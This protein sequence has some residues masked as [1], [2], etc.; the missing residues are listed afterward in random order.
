LSNFVGMNEGH[1]SLFNRC[2]AEQKELTS[3]E[4]EHDHASKDATAAKYQLEELRQLLEDVRAERDSFKNHLD[5]ARE[6]NK[7]HLRR[8][9]VSFQRG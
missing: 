1:Y 4:E 5:N 2:S 6:Q 7:Q 3:R 8:I 9:E